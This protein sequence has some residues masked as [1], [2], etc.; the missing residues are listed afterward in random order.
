MA[1]ICSESIN[2]LGPPRKKKAAEEKSRPE[3][4]F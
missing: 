2:I 3:E 1:E 4:Q